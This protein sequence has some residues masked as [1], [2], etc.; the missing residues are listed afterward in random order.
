MLTDSQRQRLEQ[1]VT[2]W[3][4]KLPEIKPSRSKW[5]SRNHENVFRRFLRNYMDGIF[6]ELGSWTGAGSTSYLLRTYPNLT[7]IAVDT[8]EGS[9]E[10]HRIEEYNKIRVNLWDHFCL[11]MQPYRGRVW[12]MKRTTVKALHILAQKTDIKPNVIY[13][14]AAHDR[15]SVFTD[16]KTAIELFPESDII[17]DD[18]VPRPGHPGV[19]HGVEDAIK[20]GLFTRNEFNLDGRVW[21]LSRKTK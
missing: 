3:P 11:N 21:Y 18:Y 15:K 7:V 1:V 12:P 5:F 6:L 9:A 14:D 8:F 16:I 10:H 13:I 17:G 20:A 2:P 19:R 4:E